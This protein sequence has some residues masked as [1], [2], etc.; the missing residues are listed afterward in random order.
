M[1]ILSHTLPFLI[2][3]TFHL[4]W[5][6]TLGAGKTDKVTLKLVINHQF[7]HFALFTM[8]SVYSIN[9]SSDTSLIFLA[10]RNK[11]WRINQVLH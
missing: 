7:Q 8:V 9:L 1:N 5:H 6:Q 11:S 3:A 10:S 4:C 2:V